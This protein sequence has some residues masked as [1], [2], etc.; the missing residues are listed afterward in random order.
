MVTSRASRLN[1]L[2]FARSA[3]AR[4]WLG[5][6]SGIFSITFALYGSKAGHSKSGMIGSVM[7]TR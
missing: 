6:V 1:R 2:Y 3:A 7:K 5:V 4:R